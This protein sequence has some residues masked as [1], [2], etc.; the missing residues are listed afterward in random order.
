MDIAPGAAA[1]DVA[2]RDPAS[3][4]GLPKRGD[5]RLVPLRLD[6]TAPYQWEFRS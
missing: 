1:I 3:L 5:G 4:F 2:A 6:F